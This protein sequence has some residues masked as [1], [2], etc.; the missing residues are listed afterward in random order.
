MI[1]FSSPTSY[2]LCGMNPNT[3][4]FCEI[5][6]FVWLD[7][8]QSMYILCMYNIVGFMYCLLYIYGNVMIAAVCQQAAE[9]TLVMPEPNMLKISPIIPSSTFQNLPI[10]LILFSYYSLCFTVSGIDIQ[11]D[12]VLIHI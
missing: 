3:I 9:G 8:I 4:Q 7:R 2:I 5:W 1:S 12:M 10:I 6:V 11:R